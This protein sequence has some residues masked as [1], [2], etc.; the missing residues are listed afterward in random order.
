M[1]NK[2]EELRRELIML[3]KRYL[4]FV[5]RFEELSNDVLTDEE[6]NE[7]VDLLEKIG[8]IQLL[9]Q[10]LRKEYEILKEKELCQK[11]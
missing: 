11:N 3:K 9:S 8:N 7:V 4:A 10:E 2:K 5:A 6:Y 1:T